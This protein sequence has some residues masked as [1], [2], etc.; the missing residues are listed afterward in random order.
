MN[1]TRHTKKEDRQDTLFYKGKG[2]FVPGYARPN[3]ATDTTLKGSEKILRLTSFSPS[4]CK[5]VG[6]PYVLI[7]KEEYEL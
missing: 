6:S 2:F 1:H 4:P 5:S 7:K 3:V